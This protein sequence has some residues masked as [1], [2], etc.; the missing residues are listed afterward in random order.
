[1]RTIPI[2]KLNGDE[3]IRTLFRD[4]AD[5]PVLVGTSEGRILLIKHLATT[6]Y[7]TGDRTIYAKT[8]D[9]NGELSGAAFVNLRYGLLD[10]IAELTSELTVTRWK[11][12]RRPSGAEAVKTVSGVFTTPVLWAGED[13][14]WWG[15]AA[16]TQ[17]TNGGRV[18][19]AIRLA[20]SEDGLLSAPWI[21]HESLESGSVTWP[22][23]DMSAAG[24]YAQFRI[25][26]ESTVNNANP[27]V[28]GLVL[29][30][31]S[32]HASYFFMTKL[33]MTKGSGIKGGLLTTAVSVPKHTEVKWGVANSNTADWNDFLSV[34]PDKLFELPDGFGDR[35]KVG[36]KLLSYDDERYP[37]IDEFAVSFDSNIDNL[38]SKP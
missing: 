3:E 14:G 1:M 37:S 16:W 19:A 11:D 38:I 5:G 12:V 32:R 6:A 23:E 31:H 4:G 17:A 34:T 28:T 26:M 35:M 36:A 20:S 29:P 21:T 9:S 24:S 27:S 13:F 25:V 22:L 8:I 15:N 2:L 30:Y 10:K 7:M 18:V 33:T